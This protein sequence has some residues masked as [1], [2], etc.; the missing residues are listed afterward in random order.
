MLNIVILCGGSGSRLWPLSRT[1][2]PKQFLNLT[3]K[4]L[5]MFQNTC[6]RIENLCY[7]QLYIICNQDHI[8]LIEQQLQDLNIVNYKLIIEPY[9]K[10][11]APAIALSCQLINSESNILVL[12][13]DHIF[14]DTKLVNCINTGLKLTDEGIVVFGITPTKPETGYGYIR[15]Q[16]NNLVTFNEKPTFEI[17]KKYLE[18]GNYLWNSG[19]FLFKNKLMIEEFQ[20]HA[21]DIYTQVKLTLENSGTFINRQLKLNPDFF[22]NV[23]PGDLS[24]D[25]AIMEKHT[26]GKVVI[27]DGLWSDIGS[28]QSLYEYKSLGTNINVNDGDIYNVETSNCYIK[29]NK[30]VATLGIENLAIVDTEDAL[31]VANKDKCQDIKK[32]VKLLEKDNK[33]EIKFHT[34]VYRPWGWYINIEGNDYSG[35]KVKKIVVLP[36]KR[37]SLQSHNYRHE[38]WVITKGTPIVQ[39]GETFI[40]MKEN[41]HIYIPIKE[42]HRMENKTNKIVEFIETQIGEYLGEDD[43]IRYQDDF[44]RI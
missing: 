4:D 21:T 6:K 14:N 13:S 17:A 11:T 33:N 7:E 36:G 20:K 31:L 29:S 25:Y 15:Y 23:N 43:I 24:I 12:A 22:K 26:S 5:T 42:K 37:L 39:L 1:L 40:K 34:R 32:I 44:G 41:E 27:Y 10:N 3:N 9:G 2:L 8:F 18:D 30:L 19:N 28:F 16:D 35:S 38:H